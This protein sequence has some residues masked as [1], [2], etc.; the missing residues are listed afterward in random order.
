MKIK[1]YLYENEHNKV[2]YFREFEIMKR[3]PKLGDTLH[4][5]EIT[6]LEQLDIDCEQGNPEAFSY[7]YFRINEYLYRASKEYFI[8]DEDTKA[9][10]IK[11]YNHVG[12]P[13]EEDSIIEDEE[14]SYLTLN[15]GRDGKD[16]F[17]YV[18]ENHSVAINIE[19]KEIIDEEE[20]LDKLFL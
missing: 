9:V 16:Y 2:R 18:D 6:K 5:E 4:G 17:W 15:V 3:I 13:T 12:I 19:T 14:N 8:D 20:Q 11:L 7:K 10:I 1:A